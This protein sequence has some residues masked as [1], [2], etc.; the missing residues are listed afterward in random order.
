MAEFSYTALV[1]TVEKRAF[2][3]AIAEATIVIGLLIGTT[4]NGFIIDDFGLDKLAYVTAGLS[5]LPL[6]VSLIFMT[7]IVDLTHSVN[8]RSIVGFDHLLGAFRTLYK[9]RPGYSRLLLNLTF[10]M[11]GFLYVSTN[12]FTSGS[13]LYFVKER[14]L[15][16]SEYSLFT[17]F[18]NL[19]RGVG[20]PALIYVINK[21]FRPDEFH[22]AMGCAVSAVFGYI[23]MSIDIFPHS[24]W[25][26]GVFLSTI[27]TYY[28]IIRANQTR[29]CSRQEVGKMFAFDALMQVIMGNVTNSLTKEIYAQ[30]LLFWPGLFLAISAFLNICGMA[31]INVFTYFN[32]K[33]NVNMINP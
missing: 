3:M 13:F 1:T 30:S 26:G 22:F 5:T 27:T 10:V 9:K 8:W 31:S 20:G 6:F 16:M 14:G 7:D 32:D 15:T 23:I 25:V 29:I 4:I 19:M 24:M 21:L 2:N 18:I 33:H 12:F 11:Y 17:G 28:S